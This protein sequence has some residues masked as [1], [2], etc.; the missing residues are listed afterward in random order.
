[1]LIAIWCNVAKCKECDAS[2]KEKC[3]TCI[4]GYKLDTNNILCIPIID[5][6]DVMVDESKC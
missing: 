2:D 6:C 3:S 4:D 1:M 5:N